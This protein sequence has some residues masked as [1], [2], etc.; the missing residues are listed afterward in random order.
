MS[1]EK[2]QLIAPLG[3]FTV[4]GLNV[5]GVVTA[6]SF[7]GNCTGTASSI[8]KG[9]NV[10]VGVMTA[11]SFVGDV[12]GN[13]TG[14]GSN[15]DNLDVGVVTATSFAGNF[16]GIG[17]GLTGTPNVV[18]G[19]VTATKFVGNTP[20][21]VSK[22]A[23]GTNINV[24]VVTATKF[25]GNTSGLAAGIAAA[26]NINVGVLTATGGLY[27]DGSGLTGAGSTAYI[28][29]V[30][31]AS[32]SETVINLNDGNII[33]FDQTTQET[34]VS[35]ANTTT[36]TDVTIIRNLDIPGFLSPTGAV[37]F[38]GQSGS[39]Q[40]LSIPDNDAWYIE[41]N[42][43]AECWFKCDSLG[44]GGWDAIFGQWPLGGTQSTNGWVL[45]YVST[46]LDFYYIPSGGSST[47]VRLGTPAL[48][49]WHHFAL[50]KS[51]SST[52]LFL[53]GTQVVS[54]FD[55]GAQQDGTGAF[56]IGGYVASDYTGQ[57]MFDGQVSN[58]RITKGQAL[59]T[60]DFTR[61]SSPLTPTSQG[62]IA[63][64]VKLLCCQDPSSAITA[65]VKPGTI[66]ANNSPSV[67]SVADPVATPFGGITWPSS[68]TWSGG[69]AP[70]LAEA[71]ASTGAAQI[72]NLVTADGGTT[73]YGYEEFNKSLV[74][75]N[76]ELFGWGDNENGELAQND[77]VLRSSPTQIPGATWSR[78]C[79]GGTAYN[80]GHSLFIKSDG[81]LWAWGINNAGALGQNNT[82]SYS[83]P[84]QIPGTTWCRVQGSDNI[85]AVKTDG[86]LWSWAFRSSMWFNGDNINQSSPKQISGSW[87]TE[88]NAFSGG[89]Y[90]SFAIRS[91]GTL[92]GVGW[93]LGGYLGQNEN[94][95]AWVSSPIQ[96]YGGGTNWKSVGV[97]GNT[98]IATKTDGT[99]WGWGNNGG[100]QIGNNTTIKYSSPTQVPGTTWDKVSSGNYTTTAT[101]TDGTL[102]TWGNN[103]QGALGLNDVTQR[104]SPTQVPGTNWSEPMAQL[105]YDGA[106]Q[107]AGGVKTDGTLW[108]W[109][110]NE[111][112]ELGQNSVSPG[113]TGYSSPVQIPGTNWTWIGSGTHHAMAL[114][115]V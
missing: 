112:G 25:V 101:K 81:T 23:D 70:T 77:V 67:T 29:Q 110:Q 80:K 102:W 6:T 60:S 87:S 30:A 114:K 40:Y 21:T 59:Y 28:R 73:W 2:A 90:N 85:M 91:D 22:L 48:N 107:I 18:A 56:T 3:H 17:S 50:S 49:T 65:T 68:I 38:T 95:N 1:Q 20:G 61:P 71:R 74:G 42:Y 33:Y 89:Y 35:F 5:S 13:V 105:S 4:P 93:R 94:V 66:T 108:V 103:S 10:V 31:T 44:T 100:G 97:M 111:R 47:Y 86:T 52:R 92:W 63:S 62:A 57:G 113:N 26:Q 39:G 43:T 9:T 76:N 19:V 55:M 79:S 98:R 64:N 82:T 34:T 46:A 12:T 109:G 14:I 53:N 24:G 115:S 88:Y 51:G 78:G 7:S 45:E 16:T 96:I 11:S 99:L 36:A 69:S 75:S 15:T 84:V 37:D 58:V 106:G 104:S 54:T 72:F 8:A 83:S 32:T 41:T 27:G